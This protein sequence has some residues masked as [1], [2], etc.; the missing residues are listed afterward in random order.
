MNNTKMKQ[1]CQ[2]IMERIPEENPQMTEVIK[3]NG[4]TRTGIVIDNMILYLDEFFRK[5]Q[6][7][8]SLE[9]IIQM[10]KTTISSAER[11]MDTKNIANFV[12]PAE[13]RNIKK[14]IFLKVVNLEMNLDRFSVRKILNRRFL[15]LAV[16]PYV[17]M[18]I[19]TT[20]ISSLNLDFWNVS[21]ESIFRLATENTKSRKTEIT[22]FLG[23]LDI[24]TNSLTFGASSILHCQETL[25]E[26]SDKYGSNLFLLPSSIYEFIVYP[27]TG[28]DKEEEKLGLMVREINHN[29]VSEEDVLSYSIYKFDRIKNCIDIVWR[30]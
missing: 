13:F 19:G 6:E 25:K 18:E 17:D 27:E 26:L 3:N 20:E 8:V 28:I 29:E 22:S 30:G 15:D 16:I 10:I 4:V 23:T 12:N 14:K 2:V 5:Y 9:K 1:F 21:E 24:M 7:N 11:T